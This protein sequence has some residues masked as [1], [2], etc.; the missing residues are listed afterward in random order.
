MNNKI[1]VCAFSLIVF[2]VLCHTGWGQEEVDYVQYQGPNP[3]FTD[4]FFPFER[5][6]RLQGKPTL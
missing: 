5:N 6:G 4:T 1:L 2:I 3:Y